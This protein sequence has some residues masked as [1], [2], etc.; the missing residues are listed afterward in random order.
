[1]NAEKFWRVIGEYN[2]STIW[3]QTFFTSQRV[4]EIMLPEIQTFG[5]C[6]TYICLLIQQ[7][8]P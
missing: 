2:Q 7:S 1:M 8:V 6:Q 5:F 3:I 4:S